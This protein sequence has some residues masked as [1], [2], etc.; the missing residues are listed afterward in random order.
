MLKQAPWLVGTT[1]SK[2]AVYTRLMN[3]RIAAGERAASAPRLLAD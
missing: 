1:A 2:G 3:R